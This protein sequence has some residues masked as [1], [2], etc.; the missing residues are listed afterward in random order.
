MTP[1]AGCGHTR[2]I[3]RAAALLVPLAL[4]GCATHEPPDSS[5]VT[6]LASPDGSV[7]KVVVLGSKGQQTLSQVHYATA[8][9][10]STTPAPVDEARFARD[11]GAAMAAR[12]IL[13]QHFVL[14][15]QKDSTLLTPESV[16]LLAQIRA[17]AQRRASAEVV[18]MGHAD[19]MG[20]FEKNED[21]SLRR[22]QA[23]AELLRQQGLHAD[24]L[25]VSAHG[26]REPL[27]GTSQ[28]T[29]E[30]RNRRVEITVR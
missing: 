17:D 6:L 16:P 25:S 29:P 1:H 19:A 4:C 21:L 8:L 30:P 7:G 26:Q 18:I 27:T 3:G 5:Y 13:P 12:P 23:V 15:F 9:D 28:A 11:F 24:T 20:R 22:A 2:R 10:G 14:Y